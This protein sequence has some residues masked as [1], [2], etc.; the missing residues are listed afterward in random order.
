MSDSYQPFIGESRPTSSRKKLI[1]AAVAVLGVVGV[2]ACT[3][4][5]T[6]SGSDNG[7]QMRDASLLS[8]STHEYLFDAF[9]T[10]HNKPY[11]KGDNEYFTRFITF[12]KNLEY[13]RYHNEQGLSYTMAV[14][15]FAD[16]TREEFKATMLGTK[17]PA[18]L[19]ASLGTF[20]ADPSASLP[21][22][23]DWRTKSGVVS[24]VKNQGQCGS[25]WAF[26]TT[27][28]LEGLA[29]VNGKTVSLSE[30]QLVDCAQKE[31]NQGCNGGLMDQGFQYVIDN[32]GIASE[33]DYPYKAKDGKCAASGKKSAF[34]ISGFKDVAKNDEDALKA[35]VAQQPIAVAIE[36][37]QS[38]FQFYHSGVFD[39]SCGTNLDHGVLVVGYGTDSGKDYWIVKN[40]WGASWG[41]KGYI[42]L[43]RHSGKSKGQ[44]GIAMQPSYPVA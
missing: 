13:I 39:G 44:C 40:S 19:G 27:G 20:E 6:R 26:S 1:V 11:K 29:G 41:D 12:K 28:A 35:A 10:Q 3:V 22:S 32:K 24:A 15:E 23:V 36:A 34:S 31:G 33:S 14:N 7:A 43:V 5:L 4:L 25:C 18:T 38:G 16:M 2:V 9:I 30:Q 42:R 8:D 37:D 21:D 17:A